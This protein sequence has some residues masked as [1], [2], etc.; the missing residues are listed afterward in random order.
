MK[1]LHERHFWVDAQDEAAIDG[2]SV[3][4]DEGVVTWLSAPIQTELP[5]ASESAMSA[6][7]TLKRVPANLKRDAKSDATFLSPATSGS[8][9]GCRGD[10][11]LDSQ[12]GSKWQVYHS[13]P[14][15]PGLAV[16]RWLDVECGDRVEV[17]HYHQ[18]MSL[19]CVV[20]L[21]HDNL[22]S[23]SD[24]GAEGYVAAWQL[25]PSAPPREP[26]LEESE[27]IH[28]MCAKPPDRW[29][30]HR[31]LHRASVV[32]TCLSQRTFTN[33]LSS[34]CYLRFAWSKA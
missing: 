34:A 27:A 10:G 33:N 15:A 11:P 31:K 7:G 6:L 14:S 2:W 19:V 1:Q 32:S 3:R 13:R 22:R 29:D 4:I 28:T 23:R 24:V 30:L 5:A 26:L 16:F 21:S 9:Y 17:V 25:L 20:S 12:V 18:R 8:G